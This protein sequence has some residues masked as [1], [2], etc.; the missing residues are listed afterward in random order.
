MKDLST[1]SS[2][3]LAGKEY[4]DF[5]RSHEFGLVL[6]DDGDDFSCTVFQNKDILIAFTYQRSFGE[7]IAVAGAGS[8][9]APSSIKARK[10]GWSLIGEIWKDAY[11]DYHAERKKLPYPHKLS[12]D[13][14]TILIVQLLGAFMEKLDSKE[15]S[16]RHPKYRMDM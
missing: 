11:Q 7:N 12:R 2:E 16:I 8:P 13:R 4:A 10:D 15:L 5:L 6:D 3:T 14:E 1:G 9:V